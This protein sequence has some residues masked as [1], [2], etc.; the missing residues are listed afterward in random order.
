MIWPDENQKICIILKVVPC[1]RKN[2]ALGKL[3]WLIVVSTLT[4][5]SVFNKMMHKKY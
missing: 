3:F 1:T 4:D 2:V 5:G